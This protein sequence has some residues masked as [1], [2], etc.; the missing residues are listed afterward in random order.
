MNHGIPTGIFIAHLYRY[1][2]YIGFFS[3]SILPINSP[4]AQTMI[5]WDKDF[6]GSN[7]EELTKI[8]QTSDGGYIL[9]GSTNSMISGDVSEALRGEGDFWI[10]KIDANGNKQWD[11]RFG[12][13]RSEN[14]QYVQQ[15]SDGGYILGGWSFSGINGD[16]SEK[17][18]GPFWTSDY[19]VVKTD[20]SGNKLWDRTFGGDG[21]EQLWHIEQTTDGGY[22][23]GGM[24]LSG[25][26]GN[27]S[28]PSRG[29]F[30]FWIV[31]ID[32]SGAMQWDKTFGGTDT[33]ML[34]TLTQSTDGG[35]LLGGLSGSGVNGDK[36]AP[37]RGVLD[38]WAIK[39]DASGNHVWDRTYG[40]NQ[41]DQLRYLRQTSD[42]G[43][44]LGGFSDSGISGNKT[45]ANRG[46]ADMWVVKVTATGNIQWDQTYGGNAQEDFNSIYETEKGIYAI[47]GFSFSG[48]SGD[49]THASRG[50]YDYWVVFADASGNL[51][52]DEAFGGSQI[53]VLYDFIRTND[54]GYLLGGHSSSDISGDKTQAN[55]GQNDQW[56][57]KLKCFAQLELG[58]DTTICPGA[59][60]TL[61]AVNNATLSCAYS[62]EDGSTAPIRTV[63][64]AS[65]STYYVTVTNVHGCTITD[66]LTVTLADHPTVDLGN[67]TTFCIGNSTILD[68]GN[69]GAT[70]LWSTT[71]NSQTI[72]VNSSGMYAVTVTDTNGCSQTDQVSVTAASS[73][74]LDLGP[75]DD[76][77]PGNSL[78]LDAGNPGATYLW[79]TS[80]TSQ[81]I[82]V[83][84][85]DTY[86][87]TVTNADGCSV[88]DAIDISIN[89][90]PSVQLG[91][92]TSFCDGNSL[93]LDAQNPGTTYLWSTTE[94]SQTISVSSAD[95]YQVTVTNADGCSTTDAIDIS[96]NTLP[97]VQLGNDTSF[98]NGT[99]LTLDAQNPGATYLWSTSETSQTISVSSADTY[100]VTVTNADGC[101]ATDAIDISIN[102][103]PSV[104]L[105]ND[106][107]FCDGNS[108]TLDAQ[109]PGA[110]YLWSTTETSQ[111]ISVSSADTYQVTV[112]NADGCSATD[113]IDISINTLPSVQ[114][115]NDTSFCD[116]NSLTLDAGNPGATY[117]WSNSETSQTISVSSADT[118]QVTVTNADGCSA[119]D[120]IDI[121]IN[122]LPSVQLGNDTSFC[123][124]NSLTL[125]AQNPGAT[126]LWSN[127]ETSQTISVSS[128][129]TYQVT[130]TNADGCSA[131]DA[132][133]ISINTLPSV[134]L[135]NDTSFCDGNSLTLD[136][137]NPGATYLWSTSETSQT[138]SVNASGN[139]SVIVTDTNGCQQSDS[140]DITV[141]PL[142]IIQLGNDTSFCNG[143]SL[144]LDAGNTGA[145]FL[146][147]TSE[148]SQTI[149]VNASGNYSVIVTDPN[150][151]QQTDSIDITVHPLPI[152]QLGNDT[153]F[154][155]GS[156]LILD[157]GNTGADFLWSTSET[158]QTISV[159]ASGNYSV[160]VTD[161]NGCQQ[162]DSIYITV[163]P[164][165]I[166]QLG[167]DTSFCN[168]NSLIL[169][170]GNTGA[171]YLWS[172]SETSQTISVNTSGN[173]AVTV[174]DTNGCQQSDSINITVHPLP[175]IQ[176]GNDTSF[177]NGNSLILDAQ[178]PGAT[179]LWSTSETSQTI[180]VNASGNYS[181][182]LTDPNGCQQTD[183]I[184]ITVHPLPIIQLGND[185]SFCNGNSLTLDAQNPGATY[186]WSTSETSQTISVNAS[187]NYS[188]IVTDTNGC[189]QTDSI[190]IT[191]HPLPIIQL[192]NDTSFCNGNSLTL[193]AGNAG[194]DFLWST[195]ETSQTISVNASGNYSVTVTDPNGCQQTDSI[196]ITVHPLPII[197][198]GND[199]SFCNGNSLTLDAGN[200]GADFLWSTNETSQNI[201][202]STSDNYAVT[203]TDTNGCQ[204]TDS[205]DITV[206]PLPIIQ[207][208]NDTSFCN[209]NSLI[210]DAGNAGADFL[211]STNETSQS[212][213]VST[214]D[215][216]AV[217]VTDTNGCQQTDSINITVHPLPIIQLGNDTSFCNGNSLT[218][219]AQ[220]PGAAYLWSTSETSQTISVNASGNY[221]VTVTDTNGCQQTDSI[222]ITVHPLPIIQLGNDTS[223]CNGNSLTLD[224]QNPGATYLWSTSE[225]SQTISVNASGN[226]SVI[227]TDTN[228]CQQTDS[229]NITVHPLPIIQLGNDT[230]FCNG[231]SLTLDAQNPGAAYLWST[232]ETSQTISVNAS[233]N[234][235]VIVTDTNGCQQ[236]DSIDITVHPLP[237]IQLGNDT[238]F[239]NG[240]SLTLDAQNPGATYLWSTSETSQTI[241]VNASGNYSVIVT[242]TNGC[243]QTDSINITVHPLPIIQ[244][245]NDTSFCDG[246]SLTL[247]AG[248]PGATYL[249]STSETS[250]TISVNASGNYS[251]TVTDTNGC[252]QSDSI[253]I[254]VHPLPIILLGNDTSFCNGNSL[255]LDAGNAGADFLWSTNETSQNISV[256]TSDNYAVTVTDTNGCQQTDSINITVH[257]L[258]IIQLGNDTSFCN[259][260]SLTLDAQNPGAAY[261][262]ST[263]ETSQTISV[264]ASGN[265]S[266]TVTDTNGCQ[267]TDSI[268]ITVHPLPIIQL[269]NDTSF[270]NGNSL[271]LDAGNA[272][273]DFLWSTNE[274]SQS[275]SVSTSGNYAVTV[276]D[277]NGCQQ[278]D[279]INISVHPLPIVLLG[280]DTS[281]CNGNSLTLDAQNPGA[282]YLWSTSETSQTI[283][284]NAS[285][286]YSVTVTDPNGCQ[287]SDSIDITVHPLPIIQLGNDTSFC[288]GNSLTLDA[289][290]AGADFLWSTNETSQSISV[291]TSGNY[292]VTVTDP[293]GCQ[294][295]DSIYITVHP[296]PIVLLG[297]DTSFCNGNSLTLDAGNAGADFLWSTNETSQ[298]ISVSISGN[299]SVTVT[300]PNGCQQTDS[301]YITVHPL[302]IVLLSSDTSFCNGNSLTLDAG[303][304]GADFLWSTNETSQSI[305]V[306]ASGNYSVTVTDPNGCQQTDSI[307]ITVHP[308]P[309]IQLGN[310]TSFCN[311]NS[312]TLDAQNPGATYL[313]STSE[314][315]QTISVNAS[316]NYSVIVTDT[317]GCQ[318]SD[319]IDITV[320]PLP[321]VLLGNDTSFCNGNSLIL[322]AGNAGA[323]FLWSTNETSQSISVS[324]SGNYSVTV[325][326]PNGCQQTDSI[327]ITVHPLPI[328]QLGND[329]SFCNGNSLIL[330]AGNAGADFLWST[331]ETS[332]SIS[333]NAS[334]N[335]S[336]T[337][338][339]PNGCQQTDSIDITVHP[340]PIVLLGND[341]SFCNGNSLTLD[342]GNTGADFL[343]STNETSQT[344]S[345]NASGNYS[346]TV[347]DPNGCQQTDSIN[348]TVHPLPIIQLGN[349][350]SFCNGNSLILDAGNAGA[351]FLWS[352]NETSQSISVSTSG[353]YSVTVTDTNGCQQSDSINITVLS[354]SDTTFVNLFSCNSLDTGVVFYQLINAQGCDSIVQ[355]V[356]SL[357][358][359]DT[360]YLQMSSCNPLDTG[361]TI[362]SLMNQFGC[363]STIFTYTSLLQS[364]TIVE[365]L[366]SC[367]PADRG[368]DTLG[369]VNQN[370]CDSIIIQ[371][372][373][374][375]PSDTLI[376]NLTSCNPI[377]TGLVI[378][379][380][381]N[382]NGCDSIVYQ[383]TSLLQ[384]DTIQ[385]TNFSCNPADTGLVITN[386]TN[387]FGCDSIVLQTTSLLL[388][389][390]TFINLNS[391]NP[392]DTGLVITNLT[393]QNGCDSIV[394]QTTSLLLSDSTF[395]NL[396][397]CNPADTGLV[398]TNLTNQNGCDSIVL[399]TTSLLLS[400]STFI[401]LNSCN[402]AD[403]GI[404]VTNLTNQN[405]CDSIVLQTTSLLLS[406]STFINLNSCNPADTGLVVTQ[407]TNQNGC[408]SIVLQTTSLNLSDSTFINLTS[409]NPAD[410]G[411]IVTNLTNQFGCDSIVLQTTSLNLSDST[412]INLASCNPADTG[413]I[414]TNL[415]NQF[416][417]DSIV[418]QTTSLNLSDS[419]FI[420]LTSCNP[421]DTG[422]VITNLI[423]QFGCDSIV[424]QTTSLNLSDSTFINL[425]SCNPADTGLVVTQLTNQN[426]CDSIVLQT[427]SLNL[428]DSTFIN[429]TSCNPADTGII[430]T[431][432]TN[433]FGC[434]SI[435]LQTTSLNLSD[436][437]FI[438]LASCNPADT[439]II[440]T[441][442][443]N[444]FGC[445]SIV[446]QTT[447]LNLS[448]STFINLTSC[449][450]ADTGIVI[451]N[452]INQ[453][454]CDSIVLQTTSLNLSDSTFINLTS[455]NPA[456]TGIV[457]TNLTNQFGCDSIVLRTTSLLLSDSTFINLTSCNPADTGLIIINLTNQFG[458]DSLLFS[459]TQLLNCQSDTTLV[460]NSSCDPL[461]VGTDTL[462]LLGSNNQDS[463]V[464]IQTALLPSD[465]TYLE[466]TSC[467]PI[468]TGLI[469]NLL[470]NQ[471]GC[472]SLIITQTDLVET[473]QQYIQQESCD[474][475]AVGTD[476][477]FYLNQ[478][479]CDSLV[480]TTT[481]FLESDTSYVSLSS[482]YPSD[483][484]LVISQLVNQAGCDSIVIT[485][486]SLLESD[487]FFIQQQSCHPQDTGI[488]I[489][490]FVNQHGC[491]SIEIIGTSLLP[492][493]TLLIVDYTCDSSFVQTNEQM[494]TNQYGCDSLVIHSTQIAPPSIQFFELTTCDPALVG[495]D[496]SFLQTT[497]GCDSLLIQ[498]TLLGELEVHYSTKNINCHGD[499]NGLIVVDSVGNEAGPYLYALDDEALTEQPFFTNL[500]AGMYFLK[501]QSSDGCEH[502]DTIIITQPP[503]LSVDAG[504]DIL[505][506]FGDSTILHFTPSHSILNWEWSPS[507]PLSCD[508]CRS[509]AITPP[510]ALDML[511][512]VKDENGC[513]AEDWVKLFVE[514]VQN[515]YIPN[516]FSPDR[517][518]INDYFTIYPGPSVQMINSFR[519]YDRWG[520]EVYAIDATTPEEIVHRG[521]DGNFKGQ[522]LGPAVFVYYAEITFADGSVRLFKG[523]L[524]LIR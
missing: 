341:T 458:C 86:Q 387:Q 433:Q 226:Y 431:N 337:V 55:K 356:T 274:T 432:L 502:V 436:S 415:T 322:D 239:C 72:S 60:V 243:Q 144:I 20:A 37:L 13:D 396:N 195:S 463:I 427:T 58:N 44:V 351:D 32:G 511:I 192:G 172:T 446:L 194:A 403:T 513:M 305:S 73:P 420:N 490:F 268:N 19:W 27:K 94:T 382:Q 445:D 112:T 127:S 402:P 400:D 109:N 449:N 504:P 291:S 289:G 233:G 334:G 507:W 134:Q 509:P 497:E 64:P 279:S 426:G 487:T 298:S 224:A 93:T 380:L 223:F 175:I 472:D 287:Q 523:D 162:T 136:A 309:I 498:H 193:D 423:N 451:T 198:L 84:S 156:S 435:V 418:L 225:T 218:L 48:I 29:G 78:T 483:T 374:L 414:V 452:L 320:H 70:Y 395:I 85:A 106:T 485:Q 342:A 471:H 128:A 163:H 299:Y 145:D 294:Q 146:W 250:Q 53:D 46:L 340:L 155:N 266:V 444:Q 183:S 182:T 62:W 371:I 353:N 343:W 389:D 366:T 276:T 113:A 45:T 235:S 50:T 328:I 499:A 129:D 349:D 373:D 216:Y 324:T 167:N 282:T 159:N 515:I 416:G 331:N 494:Y 443:T 455:C 74:I 404:V 377:D 190:D 303:N 211:W 453:F 424:L 481:N 100:Q 365:Q 38:Y 336:V 232:S 524:T 368:I 256:S 265:Y 255:I 326:D 338:T 80:E 301:I 363:D 441:N 330:D 323:D 345:V 325:T 137:Q 147:S 392:A 202:V 187:G 208:G 244:L 228:G 107:S 30:D 210:L 408:D 201:S 189:Q 281:F 54:N 262:W 90:L 495:A 63:S 479:G 310:D 397:S 206:H 465:T 381:V 76:L 399:Q 130:V 335:Y 12:G 188:V 379:T 474:P 462:Q 165:P 385:L 383:Y 185:T 10:V 429:L 140:I 169:D 304:A 91:N 34:F 477:S 308:L 394:F 102:T 412:F 164:L 360:T 2:I 354:L 108:L 99:S 66:S 248:N 378:N 121:S 207:L 456:D 306:N 49:K 249:W 88:T 290:N 135:G 61:D 213:S 318:Q 6:G 401:N 117:L 143:S 512:R 469:I 247:D 505:L 486:V 300:D 270:C 464:I 258:P 393:N 126:Y 503:P 422:I 227:V 362:Q 186:L 116:G 332:Q 488:F 313:W 79:S 361:L 158:S 103:L 491:D 222:D 168:G 346:V 514:K 132:I 82:S 17:N 516:A 138:I 142:P 296:L 286:N 43:Y 139:Y 115:G 434:D 384:S 386:L 11:K 200:A 252:Q 295:T 390:S 425:T 3:I 59:S 173:Y 358:P 302:P 18:Q 231:N 65:T 267:Q 251:V 114:L 460:F 69:P 96:I 260:N 407:L 367:N 329:T 152:I 245:G 124:G 398:I 357:L 57:I 236:T 97:S 411:I 119:T 166:V 484:G 234:Y 221:S 284:V 493:D 77:C 506:S 28:E 277:V 68:A 315:S 149:S 178:N 492:T 125:D 35:Y 161:P 209:G 519:I 437:T 293:N 459:Y 217:T 98:C 440:V 5:E 154:C 4:I 101:S 15:T 246:N 105:G 230:S 110:T 118:Y 376:L 428:S 473:D 89:T 151:C 359:S 120:A 215:N 83:S 67:D 71:E 197:Q 203:V 370:G 273:A 327:D 419:T 1:C 352:T 199:T 131:T 75:D 22:I 292:S 259:G 364:D 257:P 348:I 171:A 520:E 141:H 133:D 391:C 253:D 214:S 150:G 405:G 347:T 271:I 317:N 283:S 52:H 518:G 269:G 421:A 23:M 8:Q 375:L 442:L 333:V 123:D 148:T 457:V 242:D 238:S 153:S 174:T 311:G 179:Y 56:I 176:L 14:L 92:D 42:G 409:C 31:K 104:Q 261:L 307:D 476:T 81:T 272:G 41:N 205:I 24:S 180:S 87:V 475:M 160:I 316:G 461:T 212:I 7:F 220:N 33:D 275:I 450:P 51:L 95:T 344:I 36:T 278:S 280:S 478:A 157:A 47:G 369:F 410:T 417:C 219:D 321:I 229:I 122:T 510:H 406:D 285:G 448:D 40:G 237:I 241:S 21:S 388:S 9:G 489:N 508:T 467:S 111:T 177:C 500:D 264:N 413:I 319:S 181:V 501:T 496:T 191:V 468:D 184:D 438:N 196:D 204:Q 25:A 170:A 521:W 439:G 254:T 482:C 372:T 522:V 430:V 470:S 466:A 297:S 454:G 26:T 517:D 263:S 288:N 16:K 314:T 355:E 350:T 447:S 39:T 480:I 240:N 312:L 339:D